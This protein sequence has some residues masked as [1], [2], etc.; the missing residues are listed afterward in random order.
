MLQTEDDHEPSTKF[1]GKR[2]L[3]N[4]ED[5]VAKA[6]GMSTNQEMLEA[7]NRSDTELVQKAGID[8]ESYDTHF[9]TLKDSISSTHKTAESQ[10][11]NAVKIQEKSD[12]WRGV[13]DT[14]YFAPKWENEICR[15]GEASV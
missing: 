3:K 15:K 1:A 12:K 8:D 9:D 10:R 6:Q 11:D 5:F 14:K 13:K 2:S 4:V 7:I